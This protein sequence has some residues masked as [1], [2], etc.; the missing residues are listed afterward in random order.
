MYLAAIITIYAFLSLF[1]LLLLLSTVLGYTLEG[2]PALLRQQPT[3]AE[4]LV[5]Q[6]RPLRDAERDGRFEA[7]VTMLNQRAREQRAASA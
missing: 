6:V 2:D 1:P 5:Q 4:I 3:P 7:T